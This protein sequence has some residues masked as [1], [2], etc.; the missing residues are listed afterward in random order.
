M[1]PR[2]R[3]LLGSARAI[4]TG[5]RPP[6]A[7]AGGE[8]AESP[9]PRS[10]PASP[11][12]SPRPAAEAERSSERPP[13]RRRPIRARSGPRRY[14]PATR[15]RSETRRD[16]LRP[17]RSAGQALRP[18]E[19]LAMHGGPRAAALSTHLVTSEAPWSMRRRSRRR[20]TPWQ[21]ASPNRNRT[22]VVRPVPVLREG[23]PGSR[24]PRWPAGRGARSKVFQIR[25]LPNTM[26]EHV[27]FA[28][29]VLKLVAQCLGLD[30]VNC[31][32]G[33]NEIAVV[34]SLRGLSR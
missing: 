19:N 4:R 7:A 30:A 29:R 18:I 26:Y 13:H 3:R 34:R 31:R 17:E 20:R 23:T 12:P 33:Q 21:P 22:L 8:R 16:R 32:E 15:A 14:G 25:P 6:V 5:L 24:R 9:P 1:R 27:G 11:D 10:R 2:P 28:V